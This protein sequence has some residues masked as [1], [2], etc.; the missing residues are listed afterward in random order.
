MAGEV[1]HIGNEDSLFIFLE[2]EFADA[3]SE[4]D[5][6]VVKMHMGEPGNSTHITS[7]FTAKIVDALVSRGCRPVVFDSPVVYKSPRNTE[8]GY[9]ESAADK[10]FTR[11]R[12]GAP[13]IVSDRSTKIPGELMDYEVCSEPL[14]A[15]GVLILSHFKGHICSG[16]GGSI[17]N[18]GMGCMSKR[19]KGE[20]HAGGEPVYTGGCVECGACVEGCPTENIR[21]DE[22]RP[23]F[24]VTWCSGCSNCVVSCP[25]ECISPKVANF[26]SLLAE[27]AVTASSRFGK[28]YAV[29]VMRNMTQLCDCI[30]DPGPVLAE[31]IGFV[32]GADMVSVDAASLR[33][34]EE[35]TGMKDLFASRNKKSSYTHVEEAASLL[36]AKMEVT[37]REFDE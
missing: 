12:L 23:F 7:D 5:S 25:H 24:D 13:V 28:T 15:D 26:D 36:G 21:L 35:R 32:C 3:F 14:E 27:A 30:A 4:G 18:V 1:T 6:I 8:E 22:G 16:M 37:I 29:N 20:I 34:L 33:L 17:K 9:L 10:G 31:D 19:T 2:K 11:D